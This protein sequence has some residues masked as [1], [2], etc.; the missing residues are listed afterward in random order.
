MN[1]FAK[2]ATASNASQFL[3]DWSEMNEVPYW[4]AFQF[5]YQ[6]F[7]KT[8]ENSSVENHIS[9][10]GKPV[11][12]QWKW[13]KNEESVMCEG[14]IK[15]KKKISGPISFEDFKEIPNSEFIH[16]QFRTISQ[17]LI[18]C[19]KREPQQKFTP[20]DESQ[21]K[22]WL[23]V[24][25]ELLKEALKTV[26]E[27]REN[28]GPE[29]L[30][31][32]LFCGTHPTRDKFIFRLRL[33]NLDIDLEEDKEG[34]FRCLVL[35]KKGEESFEGLEPSLTMVFNREKKEVINYFIKL[36]PYIAECLA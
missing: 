31:G 19:G 13:G 6:N 3:R 15:S 10:K 7:E 20:Q 27:G 4:M 28:G 26:R 11:V 29:V 33:F 22:E 17:A 16:Q 21:G 18:D 24:T 5:N 30:Q 34:A 12:N 8:Y 14:W 35:N 9:V 25:L 1:I 2:K 23:R 32:L 36:L